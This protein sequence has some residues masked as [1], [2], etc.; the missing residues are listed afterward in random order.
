M[1][2]GRQ[3][4]D[5]GETRMARL[6]GWASV[7]MACAMVY[8]LLLTPAVSAQPPQYTVV[9]LTVGNTSSSVAY[10]INA[11]GQVVGQAVVDGT[12]TRAVL[13]ADGALTDLGSLNGTYNAAYG[14]QRQH[15]DRR[16]FRVHRRP[17]VRS[18]GTTGRSAISAATR[19]VADH[20]VRRQRQRHGRRRHPVGTRDPRRLR[21]MWQNGTS[22]RASDLRLPC[23]GC[24]RNDNARDINGSGQIVGQTETA[25]G[26]RAALWQNGTVT[27]LGTLGGDT[28]AAFGINESG[29]VVGQAQLPSAAPTY[30]RRGRSSGRTA[31]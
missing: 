17:S 15:A 29:H 3:T 19:R 14:D 21:V 31:P 18:S 27:D 30:A 8:G 23:N 5:E 11:S 16:L 2:R 4:S 22:D 26:Q 13:W 10:D 25:C 24:L 7:V 28:S 9:Q 1:A 6:N 20:G 12:P